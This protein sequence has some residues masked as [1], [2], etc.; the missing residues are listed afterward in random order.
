MN[1]YFTSVSNILCLRKNKE[2]AIIT[3]CVTDSIETAIMN[4]PSKRKLCSFA[5]NNNVFKLKNITL[6]HSV[7]I[8]SRKSSVKEPQHLLRIDEV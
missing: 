4:H 7:N 6:K 3:E 5:Q 8:S 1:F 2:I